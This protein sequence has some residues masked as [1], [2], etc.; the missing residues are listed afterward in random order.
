MAYSYDRTADFANDQAT[1]ALADLIAQHAMK[2]A[3]A[4]DWETALRHQGHM[5][6]LLGEQLRSLGYDGDMADTLSRHVREHAR[7][8]LGTK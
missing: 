4:K 5:C 2:A 6:A 3:K 1:A 7:H 8:N